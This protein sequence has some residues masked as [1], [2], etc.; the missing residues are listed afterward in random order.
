VSTDPD[1]RFE[2]AI[3][4]NDLET[5]LDLVRASP[6]AGSQQKWKLVGDKALEAWQMDL[7]KEAFEKAN[8]LPALLLLFT[9]LSDRSGLERLAKLAQEKGSNNIAFAAFLQL[10]DSA[11]CISLLS[12]TGRL[13][14]AALF[15]RSYK[16]DLIPEVV[17]KW[18]GELESGGKGKL[19]ETIGTSTEDRDLFGELGAEG[20]S[21]VAATGEED[22][23]VP[24]GEGSGIMVEKEDAEGS[25]EPEKPSVDDQDSKSEEK[26]SFKDKISHVVE[27][28]IKEPVEEL[29]DKV[30][31]LAVG[32]GKSE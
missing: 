16:P 29:A 18:K 17:T 30:K 32:N 24:D 14:E 9:S 22:A 23:G 19:A 25:A 26:S 20:E 13:P 27:E 6:E 5:A 31:D 3:A 11:S 2:L 8:D 21:P 12:Q 28:K 15:A 1:H 4:L 7:A 10:G